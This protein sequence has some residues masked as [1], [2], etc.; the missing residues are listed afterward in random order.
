MDAS[1]TAR[2][3]V[4]VIEHQPLLR[5]TAVDFVEEAGFEALEACGADEAVR[6]LERRGDVRVVFSDLDGAGGAEGLK[7]AHAIRDRWPPVGLIVTSG[8][9]RPALDRLP[10]RGLFFAKP[11]RRREVA[12][13]LR[14][15]AA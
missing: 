2:A 13:A 14:R 5:I 8:R 15:M 3:A 11:Y 7:L 6:I 12:E 10:A 1:A 4:L 9:P